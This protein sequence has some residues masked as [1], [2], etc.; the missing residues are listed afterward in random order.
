M[1][2]YLVNT[3][4]SWVLVIAVVAACVGFSF[5]ITSIGRRLFGTAAQDGHNDVG[6]S[7]LQTLG[8][9]YAVLLALVVIAL[10]DQ[11]S[12][13]DN[14]A[15]D[16]AGY[17]IATYRDIGGLPAEFAV[18]ARAAIVDYTKAV[19]D[20]GYPALKAG[21]PSERSRSTFTDMFTMIRAFEPKT[22]HDEMIYAE[23]LRELNQASEARSRRVAAFRG[24]LP[25]VFWAVI[26][27]STA[28]TLALGGM[29]AMQSAGHHQLLMAVFAASIGVLLFLVLVL[30]RPFAGDLGVTPDAFEEAVAA[31]KM[32]R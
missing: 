23:A 2:L 27:V 14:Y 16:E 8:G 17:L 30:D 31:M 13:V 25:P 26:V 11:R 3:F 21:A 10:W 4:P 22:R 28:L 6:G 9:V 19:I 12:N 7:I 15:S 29:L 24:G 20:V 18:P 1:T 5:L 32:A